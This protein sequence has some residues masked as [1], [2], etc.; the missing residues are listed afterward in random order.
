MVGEGSCGAKATPEGVIGACWEG[1]RGVGAG[2]QGGGG[3]LKM[4]GW[5]GTGSGS[6]GV[7][8]VKWTGAGF[9]WCEPLKPLMHCIERGAERGFDWSKAS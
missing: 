6:S 2:V 4:G 1:V 3:E 8:G 5:C 9:G 7:E